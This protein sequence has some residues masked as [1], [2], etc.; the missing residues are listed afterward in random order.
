MKPS[1]YPTLAYDRLLNILPQD[2]SNATT[3]H[4][5][6][7]LPNG[8]KYYKLCLEYH[9]TTNMSPDEVYERGKKHI[10]LN[11]ILN[12][13]QV[14]SWHDFQT[15]ITNFENDSEQ[16]FLMIIVKSCENIDNEIDKYF[17]SVCR[18]AT[19]CI[20]ERMPQLKEATAVAVH[21]FPATFYGKTPEKKVFK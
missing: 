12:E 15:S 4:G 11:S 16:K 13:K 21:Y 18:P 3:D 19:K 5:V 17:L 14:E 10:F 6:W 2:L 8:D 20:V 1:P 9:T 7:K